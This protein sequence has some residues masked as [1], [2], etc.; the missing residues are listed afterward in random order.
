MKNIEGQSVFVKNIPKNYTH[1]DL[2]DLFKD[3]GEIRS[4]KISLSE[5][6]ENNGF[7][8]VAFEKPET[9]VQAIKNKNGFKVGE[10]TLEVAS[11]KKQASSEPKFNNLYVKEFPVE[12]TDDEIKAHFGQIGEILSVFISRD[13]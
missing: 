6:H 4:C 13:E 1:K 9:A 5:D 2:Y 8:Y 3:E 12:T 11:Y 10:N 7:G